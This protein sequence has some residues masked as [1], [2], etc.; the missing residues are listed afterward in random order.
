MHALYYIFFYL[1]CVCESAN[2]CVALPFAR[3]PLWFT[4]SSPIVFRFFLLSFVLL[5]THFFF[6]LSTHT[7]TLS[8]SVLMVWRLYIDN[9]HSPKT[10]NN[11]CITHAIVCVCVCSCLFAVSFSHSHNC[12]RL[13]RSFIRSS[14][15]LTQLTIERL[16][17]A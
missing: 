8:Q 11:S 5:F 17:F 9:R 4:V 10:I 6:I 3:I 14:E 15:T 12:Y 2:E 13:F 16:A 1:P 7:L